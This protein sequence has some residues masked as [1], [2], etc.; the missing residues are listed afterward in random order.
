MAS[1]LHDDK[2]RDRRIEEIGEYFLQTGEST[3]K[4]AAYF[5]QY[6]YPISNY[7]VDQYLKIYLKRHYLKKTEFME[8]IYNNKHTLDNPLVIQRIIVEKALYSLG[9]LEKD[10]ANYYNISESTVSRDL[11]ERILSNEEKNQY[12]KTFN[13]DYIIDDF[14]ITVNVRS[15]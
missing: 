3:R 2:E 8:L 14:E 6:K 9:Y 12:L 13:I 5:T 11:N 15:K 10:I 4:I 7:T 1:T